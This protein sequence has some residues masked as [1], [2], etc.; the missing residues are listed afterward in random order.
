MAIGLPGI[1]A[2]TSCGG[3]G[4]GE[5]A[6]P[7]LPDG[8]AEVEAAFVSLSQANA[9]GAEGIVHFALPAVQEVQAGGQTWSRVRIPGCECA[10]T[11][12]GHPEVPARR[13]FLAVPQGAQVQVELAEPTPVETRALKL[14][15]HQPL[16]GEFHEVYDGFD[17]PTPEEE[18]W[19][20]AFVHDSGAYATNARFPESPCSVRLCGDVGDLRLAVVEVA[21]GHYEP[22]SADLTLYGQVRFRI[23]FTGG[24]ANY[25]GPKAGNPFESATELGTH[26]AENQASVLPLPFQ[27]PEIFSSTGEELLILTTAEYA[28]AANRLAIHRRG[29]GMLTRVYYVND[30][31]GPAPDTASEIDAWIDEHWDDCLV[32]PSY[33]L[34]LGDAADIPTFILPRRYKETDFATDYPYGNV[35]SDPLANDFFA[36]MAVGRIPVNSLDQADT[37]VD[38]I[39]EYESSGS[40]LI[41][42]PFDV[43]VASEFQCCGDP[44]PVGREDGRSFLRRSEDVR[45]RLVSVGYD[46]ERIYATHVA[47]DYAEDP[48]PRRWVDGSLLPPPLRPQDGFA[49]D[50]DT[51]DVINAF[52][53]RRLFIIHHDHGGVS[54]WGHPSF[55]DDPLR[56]PHE[57][58]LPRRGL[59]QLFVGALRR[60]P[61][62]Q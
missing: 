36:N 47:G 14:Y 11:R 12:A 31:A 16:A 9:Q 48:T 34:L 41:A 62:L 44:P 51:Q 52:N 58:L 32:R 28:S 53:T 7:V 22:T 19:F 46:V 59:L 38:K 26:Y 21:G 61:L 35:H 13:F 17:E 57:R 30:G 33:L 56:V 20:P 23:G 3:G 39:I 60:L 37:V 2:V 27:A 54:G 55:N 10:S 43:T 29:Q 40:G 6:G 1:V 8:R 25:V 42:A 50:G 15:P 24:S 49:W 4:G 5:D 45:E 18:H